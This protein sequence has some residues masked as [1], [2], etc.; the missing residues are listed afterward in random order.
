MSWSR[1]KDLFEGEWVELIDFDW[2]WSSPFPKFARVRNH[3]SDRTELMGLIAAEGAA[4]NSVI[5]YIGAAS[6]VINRETSVAAL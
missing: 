6:S 1:I 3:A 4:S 2:E 5:L